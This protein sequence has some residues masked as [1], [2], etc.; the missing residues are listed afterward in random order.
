MLGVNAAVLLLKWIDWVVLRR[1]EEAVWEVE[2]RG[3]GPGPKGVEY[4]NAR[5]KEEVSGHSGGAARGR[6][7]ETLWGR[8]CWG[9]RLFATNRGVGWNWKVKNVPEAVP[10]G[11][12]KWS[13][14]SQVRCAVC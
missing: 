1:A 13:V 9:F 2:E 4:G 11:F 14:L 10:L 3:P 12:S 8:F 7:P 5:L 6:G